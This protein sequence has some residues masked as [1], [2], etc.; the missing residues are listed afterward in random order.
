MQVSQKYIG[1]SLGGSAM[2]P[3][4]GLAQVYTREAGAVDDLQ[5]LTGVAGSETAV[6]EQAPGG[7][8]LGFPEPATE[9]SEKS[10]Q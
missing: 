6:S 1:G 8:L 3:F 2:A 4:L 7:S 5:H 9:S 10:H